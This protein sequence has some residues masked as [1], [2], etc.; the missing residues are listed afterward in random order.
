MEALHVRFVN[1]YELGNN[2]YY[3][4][5]EIQV[6][7]DTLYQAITNFPRMENK[8]IKCMESLSKIKEHKIRLQTVSK[9]VGSGPV[10]LI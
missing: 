2:S 10:Y 6:L 9:K 3:I 4:Q 5:I 1:E 8:Q 7:T